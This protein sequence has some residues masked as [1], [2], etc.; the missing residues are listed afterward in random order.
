M[1][2]ITD[3]ETGL[4]ITEEFV[5]QAASAEL[6]QEGEKVEPIDFLQS[7][8]TE[9]CAHLEAIPP[10]TAEVVSEE[11]CDAIVLEEPA[12]T[13]TRTTTVD[14]LPQAEILSPKRA[15]SSI[16]EDF[17]HF[18]RLH[19]RFPV[20]ALVVFSSV[21]TLRESLREFRELAEAETPTDL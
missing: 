16:V 13:L 4:D 21:A 9:L 18:E 1:G 10:I 7:A 5:P 19:S 11:P 12:P 8:I 6:I 3:I 15:L 2:F 14:D 17:A 20:E